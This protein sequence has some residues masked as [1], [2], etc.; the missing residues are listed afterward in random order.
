MSSPHTLISGLMPF[1]VY[2]AH[3]CLEA[4][5]DSSISEC[6][7]RRVSALRGRTDTSANPGWCMCLAVPI[8]ALVN[9]PLVYCW[10]SV[11]Q[12]QCPQARRGDRVSKFLW[13]PGVLPS[14]EGKNGQSN[15]DQVPADTYVIERWEA[16]VKCFA[17]IIVLNYCNNRVRKEI[18]LFLFEREVH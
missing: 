15:H 13:V 14:G 4:S 10:R 6:A 5:R 2:G 11:L 17:R 8:R 18:W 3:L 16:R 9:L 1:L 7:R 12:A